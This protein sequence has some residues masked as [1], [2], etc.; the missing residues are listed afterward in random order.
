MAYTV[1]KLKD[2]SPDALEKAV[3]KLLSALE[4]EAASV[5]SESEYEVFRNHWRARKDGVVTQVNEL[6]RKAAPKEA[7]RS[8]GQCINDIVIPRIDET[9]NEVQLKVRNLGILKKARE[10]GIDTQIDSAIEA[11]RLSE[12]I[13]IS[14]PGIHRPIGAEH[15]IIRT[16]NEIVAVFKN[17]GYSVAEGPVI[18]TDYYNFEALNFP[19]NH[20]ARDTQ[21]TLFLAN[22]ESKPRREQLGRISII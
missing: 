15:P 8:V 11:A 12:R 19:P 13:D 2:F 21:D 5:E 10:E 14:F 17:L 1:P 7:I 20:P 9:I 4:K 22:Q 16:Q 6:W 3:E 18:E